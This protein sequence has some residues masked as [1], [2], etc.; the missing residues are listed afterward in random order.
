MIA[1]GYHF[2]EVLYMSLDKSS[3]NYDNDYQNKNDLC[4]RIMFLTKLMYST[5]LRMIYS[6]VVPLAVI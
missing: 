1:S 4:Q 3:R 6:E 2:P 5:T